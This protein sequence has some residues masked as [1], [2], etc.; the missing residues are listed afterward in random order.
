[1]TG[2]GTISAKGATVNIHSGIRYAGG[3]AGGRIYAYLVYNTF[4]GA[5]GL[6]G[7]ISVPGGNGFDDGEDG[8]IR[9]TFHGDFDGDGMPDGWELFHGVSD[10][11]ADEDDDGLNNLGE[12][13]N[14]T[15]PNNPDCDGDN[16]KDGDEILN[17]TDPYDVDTDDDNIS[18]G[19]EV[20]HGFDPLD[21][22]DP[23]S[24]VKIWDNEGPDSLW[25]T[26]SN[27]SG[28]TLPVAGDMVVFMTASVANCVG[29]DIPS[30][31]QDILLDFGYTGTL[32]MKQNS[33]GGADTLAV[34]GDITVNQGNIVCEGG[35]AGS[36][37]GSPDG[38]GITFQAANVTVGYL[39]RI[40]ANGQGFPHDAG[41]GTA[42]NAGD[43]S[44]GGG[45]GGKGGNGR[46]SAGGPTY[47]TMYEP[48]ALGSGGAGGTSA[49]SGGGAIK[50]EVTNTITVDG[51]VSA[52][53]A[54]GSG[55]YPG[56]S[57]GSIWLVCDTL[58][59]DGFII[60]DGGNG[61]NTTYPGGGGG[62]RIRLNRVTYAYT[63]TIEAS[64]G[65]G[66]SGGRDGTVYDTNPFLEWTGEANYESD[67]LDPE[68][69][70]ENTYLSHQLCPSLRHSPNR[71]LRA[72]IERRF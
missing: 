18:D 49:G 17:N 34:T 21:P 3:G 29:D 11:N 40:H 57:G 61:G 54:K 64:G 58:T 59:G 14:D 35:P 42:A 72:Y 46:D 38:E 45:Y 50:F 4:N 60:A 22:L 70:K 44:G 63:C 41:P 43:C 8:T 31:L 62:G 12:Y 28:D 19:W 20:T 9:Y 37:T 56:G 16:L 52:N 6:G 24:S 13:Q 69:G 25:S 68:W 10:P 15:D 66:R 47:G 71:H 2:T 51:T 1:M 65:S 48:D 36:T 5:A 32:T 39:G 67:G 26:P 23:G 33:I 7:I 30:N 53:G 27:W 55:N